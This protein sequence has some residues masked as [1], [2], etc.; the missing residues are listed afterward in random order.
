MV[1]GIPQRVILADVLTPSYRIVGKI[2]VSHTGLI[3]LLNDATSSVMSVR[4]AGMARLN[5]PT[6]LVD[7]FTT[8][9][10]VKDRIFAVS[11]SR[12]DDVGPMAYARGGYGDQRTYH[13]R[14]VTPV[15]ELDGLFE[16]SGRFDLHAILVDGT[17]DH[18]PLFDATLTTVFLPKMRLETPAVLFNRRQVDALALVK[19][20]TGE[21]TSAAE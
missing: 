7:R 20:G 17:R 9:R 18:L 14:M 21:L 5:S 6:K 15:F 16:W 1:S 8:V 13:V 11:L 12:R 3:G 10:V 19:G 2:Q 4:E